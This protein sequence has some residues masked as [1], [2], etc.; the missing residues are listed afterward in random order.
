MEG[1]G[2]G[3]E[4]VDVFGMVEGVLVGGFVAG[5]RRYGG[6]SYSRF[7]FGSCEGTKG[8][9]VPSIG[10]RVR[11]YY[12]YDYYYY[13]YPFLLPVTPDY[14]LVF[15]AS[16]AI[17]ELTEGSSVPLK[18]PAAQAPLPWPDNSSLSPC[19]P[20]SSL[21]T[22]CPT[23]CPSSSPSFQPTCAGNPDVPAR[24]SAV[25]SAICCTCRT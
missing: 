6:W 24:R 16:V 3:G 1:A 22:S 21:P 12:Y 18:N 19:Y 20:T 14:F 8:G 5:G 10:S 7:C 11:Y 25:S 15:A 9:F 4:G 23:S 13:R 17:G 2:E